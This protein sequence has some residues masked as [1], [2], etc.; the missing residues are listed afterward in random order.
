[1]QNCTTEGAAGSTRTA[2]LCT[3]SRLRETDRVGATSTRSW[4]GGRAT[5]TGHPSQ[6]P[7]PPMQD[8]TTPTALVPH[9]RADF[10]LSLAPAPAHGHTRHRRASVLGRSVTAPS[11]WTRRRPWGAG[12]GGTAAGR[13]QSRRARA[14]AC[15]TGLASSGLEIPKLLVTVPRFFVLSRAF[16]FMESNVVPTATLVSVPLRHKSLCGSWR[17]TCRSLRRAGSWSQRGAASVGWA[18]RA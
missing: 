14:G 7:S 16:D 15:A 1:M 3:A 5:F 10:W 11:R 6:W 9:V 4:R 18:V 12:R 8:Q 2:R 13:W 17:W